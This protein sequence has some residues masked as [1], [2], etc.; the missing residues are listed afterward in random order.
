VQL[1]P[2]PLARREAPRQRFEFSG[3]NPPRVRVRWNELL[4]VGLSSPPSFLDSL[5]KIVIGQPLT[6]KL[7]SSPWKKRQEKQTDVSLPLS[8]P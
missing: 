8:Q 4:G 5:N 3:P 7:S 1:T 6:E 2:C